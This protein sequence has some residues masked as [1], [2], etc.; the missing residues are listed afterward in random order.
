MHRR[1]LLV[2]FL[3]AP[4]AAEAQQAGN[5]PRIGHLLVLPWSC[6]RAL[7]EAFRQRRREL[8]YV[9]VLAVEMFVVTLLSSESAE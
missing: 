7:R 3:T 4:L 9:G 8:R 6:N 5:V 1:A 2:T